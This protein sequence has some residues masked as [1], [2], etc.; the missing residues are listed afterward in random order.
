MAHKIT[1]VNTKENLI[2]VI[3]FLNGIVKEYD[4]KPLFDEYPQ[5][6]ALEDKSL[7]ESVQIDVGGYGISWNDNLDLE[8]E[9]LWEGG[10]AVARTEVSHNAKL[11]VKLTEAR[12]QAGLT[13]MQLAERTGIYQADISKIER[14]LG[15][16]SLNTLQRLA[17]GM[18]KTLEV[19]FK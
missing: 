14:G 9:T 13:Q 11:A 7:F 8:A 5:L 1:A 4:I 18:G 19:N 15:N 6:K 12:E 10:V 17:V 2:I 16:P 3:T